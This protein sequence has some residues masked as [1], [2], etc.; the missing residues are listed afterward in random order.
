MTSIF[1]QMLKEPSLDGTGSVGD[2]KHVSLSAAPVE[3]LHTIRIDNM[4]LGIGWATYQEMIDLW[5]S[6]KWVDPINRQTSDGPGEQLRESGACVQL[7]KFTSA[8]ISRLNEPLLENRLLAV[9]WTALK[10]KAGY[11]ALLAHIP[12]LDTIDMFTDA[13]LNKPA[14]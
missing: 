12:D 6:W 11:R 8:S 5:L 2:I 1:I 7:G 9:D 4:P 14:G 13:D 10:P 3:Y